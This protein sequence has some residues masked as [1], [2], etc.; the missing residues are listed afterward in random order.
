MK[1]TLCLGISLLFASPSFADN[2][3][4]L[5]G[6]SPEA[7]QPQ[8]ECL[9]IPGSPENCVRALACVGEDGLYFDGRVI[10]WNEGHVEGALSDGTSCSGKWQ[11]N[12]STGGVVELICEDGTAMGVLYST[13]DSETGTAIGT[14]M[15]NR[16]RR[17]EGWSGALVLDYLTPE[18]KSV[19]EL[20]CGEEAIPIS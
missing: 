10:G 20:P 7:D 8:A 11:A 2:T 16:N 18:G 19:A 9:N 14:G 3:L 6:L 13:L 1:S 4:R 12:R 5:P 15:D 17:I